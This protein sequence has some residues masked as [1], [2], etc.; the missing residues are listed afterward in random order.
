MSPSVLMYI[1]ASGAAFMAERVF[2]G[3]DVVRYSLLAFAALLFLGTL[4]SRAR[5]IGAHPGSTKLALVFY[6]ISASAG[7]LYMLSDRDIV[8]GLI[9]DGTKAKQIQT[10]I[11]CLAALVWAVGVFPAVA[12]DRTLT[13]SPHSLHPLRTRA[14]L[15][16][17]LSVALG[18][19]MLFPINY[20]GDAYNKKWDFGF[21]K[22][23]QVGTATRQIT[24]ALTDPVK[25][26]L[27]FPPSSDVLK[28][29]KPYF[30]DLQGSNVTF[31]TMDAVMDP[32]TAKKWKVRDNGNIAF[33]KGEG[34]DDE[35]TEILK[36]TDKIETAKK[37]LRKLDSKVQTSLL[38]LVR[39]KR[40]VYFTVGHGEMYW[41]NAPSEE[42]NIDNLKK[43]LEALNFK[44]KELGADDGLAQAVPDDAGVVFIAAPQAPFLPEEIAALQAF[45]DKG[46]SFFVMFR[47]GESVDGALAGLFGLEVDPHE[48]LSDKTF[49]KRTG[50]LTDRAYVV[51]NKFGSHESVTTLSKN[52]SQAVFIAPHMV[53]LAEAKEHT[54]KVTMTL[55]SMADWFVDTNGN[56]E[57]DKDVEKRGGHDLAA[58]AT[59]PA[60][61]GAEWRAT[62]VGSG[63]WASNPLLNT[64]A[65]SQ[66]VGN[67]AFLGDSVGWLTKD[68]AIGGE[69]ENE[70]DVKITHTKEGQAAWFYGLTGG[71]PTLLFLAGVLRV[72]SRKKKGAA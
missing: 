13:A 52:A 56:F 6:V 11:E 9:A 57:F 70:E 1:F 26:V 66:G 72:N 49:L 71:V 8:G 24:D 16:G 35:K 50:G 14:A 21:F 67:I 18:L 20:L 58:I 36:L 27:F 40:T 19:A 30:Q 60:E 68:P 65:M 61:G 43:V 41:R 54:G 33:I 28:E 59:G 32:E 45:R 15:E 63:S 23:T 47:P 25:V 10:A 42:E 17:G 5:T 34:T 62:V 39:E 7:L 12:L 48:V 4:A 53:A 44:V 2:S 46:G 55:K 38:K 37:D 31:E 3:N 51:T 22:T 64:Q 29:I 69:T